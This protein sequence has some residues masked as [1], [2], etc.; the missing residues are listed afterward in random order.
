MDKTITMHLMI[1]GRVQ[2]VGLRSWA[3]HNAV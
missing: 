2:G 1:I 3:T